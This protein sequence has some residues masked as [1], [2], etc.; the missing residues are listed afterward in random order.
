MVWSFSRCHGFE[1]CKYEWYL[2]Y[3]LKDEE[4]KRIYDNE[5]NFY[6]SF[7][8][9]CHDILEQVLTKKLDVADAHNYYITHFEDSVLDDVPQK[10][11][12]KYYLL[13]KE[14]FE[15]LCLEW[16]SKYRILGVEKKCSF[17]LD[18][19]LFTGYIDL[20]LEDVETG[21]IIMVDHKSSEYPIGQKG[22]VLKNKAS[23]YL[24]YQRQQYLYSEQVFNE[25]GKYPTKLCWNYFRA[26]KWHEIPFHY[27][28]FTEAREWALKIISEANEESEFAPTLNYFY[29]NNLCGFRNSCE[30]KTMGDPS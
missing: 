26:G 21:D 24:S 4:G 19:K 10:T 29:C 28:D 25:F 1:G 13:G 12:E 6:A 7:G 30:Y 16:L 17:F 5:Q 27:G 9:Y 22:Q 3:L 11:R 18:G 15:N 23:D 2:N 20:L 14:Y 8:K